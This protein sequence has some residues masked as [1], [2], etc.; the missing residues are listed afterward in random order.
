MIRDVYVMSCDRKSIGRNIN[1]LIDAGIDIATYDENNEGYYLREPLFDDSEVRML[2][3]SVLASRYISGSYAQD[4]IE[5]LLNLATVY[6]G[7]RIPHV[8]QVD[9]WIHTDNPHVF[10]NIDKLDEAIAAKRKV[11]FTYNRY[12]LDMK[13]H[14]R[15][16]YKYEVDPYQIACCNGRYYLIGNYEKHDGVTNFRIDLIT[17]VEV[18]DTRAVPFE[19]LPHKKGLLDIAEYIKYALNMYDGKKVSAVVRLK[20]ERIGDIID[21]FGKDI[22]ILSKEDDGYIQVRVTGSD[23]GIQMWAIQYGRLVEVL[24]PA[25]LREAIRQDVTKMA[26]KYQ[27]KRA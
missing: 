6:L 15:H 18:L 10:L 4:L 1:A 9:R 24:S 19:S 20:E 26:E 3:D 13:L 16:D 2:I 12:E 22:T 25:D 7:K 8:L 27:E 14:P 11:R 23:R 5:K 21:W 17:D